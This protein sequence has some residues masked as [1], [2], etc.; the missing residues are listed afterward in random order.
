[1]FNLVNRLL[2]VFL[3]SLVGIP[4]WLNYG[5]VHGITLGFA[6]FYHSRI[7]FKSNP[8]VASFRRFLV[9]VFV[10]RI[11]DYL[12]VILVNQSEFILEWVYRVPGIGMFLGDNLLYLS[13]LTAS[14]V[15]FFIRYAIFTKF[16]FASEIPAKSNEPAPESNLDGRR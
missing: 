16:T 5:F 11:V 7:T 14:V 10:L 4:L 15:I 9:S 2:L 6:F 12:F 3:L 8:S 1:M 13:I